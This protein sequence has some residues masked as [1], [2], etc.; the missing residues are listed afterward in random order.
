MTSRSGDDDNNDDDTSD[1]IDNDDDGEY[2]STY[3]PWMRIPNIK[4]VHI[5]NAHC[6][7]ITINSYTRSKFPLS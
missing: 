1:N 4:W 2:D 7:T 6:Y 3:L 5:S